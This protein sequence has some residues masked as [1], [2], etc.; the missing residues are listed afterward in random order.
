MDAVLEY[1]LKTLNLR[2]FLTNYIEEAESAIKNKSSYIEYLK[3][4]SQNEVDR[5][6]NQLIQSRLKEARF[7]VVKTLDTFD[8]SHITSIKKEMIYQLSEGHFIQG[9]KN[10]IFFGPCGTGKTHLAAALGR[11]LCL[12]K[13]R[14][15]FSNVCNFIN[16]LQ[17]AN[18][19]LELNKFF[20]RMQKYD[21]IILDELGYVPFEKQATNLLFQFF[22][23]CYERKSLLITT[24][25][26]FSQW[27]QIFKEKQTTVAAVDRLIHH[28]YIIEFNADSFRLKSSIKKN[29]NINIE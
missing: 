5:R 6:Y 19:D 4:L 1:N 13:Y 22:A 2:A 16:V 28:G 23:E 8:F 27:D 3:T 7:P 12:K 17:K 29:K 18:Q 15:Y 25:L 9:A 11:E 26:A 21:L 14:V 24:N 20:M 10:I